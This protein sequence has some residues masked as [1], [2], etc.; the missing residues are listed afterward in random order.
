[1]LIALVTLYMELT[2]PPKAEQVATLRFG[3]GSFVTKNLKKN[4]RFI[5]KGAET[6]D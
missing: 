5:I 6:H 2:C 4:N 3:W 1:L